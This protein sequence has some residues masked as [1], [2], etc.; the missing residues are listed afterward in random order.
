MTIAILTRPAI[1][2]ATMTSW[3]EKCSS[4]LRSSSLRTGV[5]DLWHNGMH[6]GRGPIDGNNEHL[7]EITKP[8]EAH[9]AAD[10]QLDGPKAEAFE[11]Q[12][13]IGYDRGNSHSCEQGHVKQ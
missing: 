6:R 13:A 5:G 12:N 4:F 1:A 7:D 9:Q 8:D 10:D 2:S 11:H 3:L